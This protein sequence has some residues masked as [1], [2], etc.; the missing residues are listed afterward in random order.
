MDLKLFGP[1]CRGWL[2]PLSIAALLCV[3]FAPHPGYAEG[4]NARQ[5]FSISTSASAGVFF[6]QAV[7]DIY[8]QFLSKDYKN[9]ELVWPFTPLYYS[10]A[11]LSLVTRMGF[12]ADLDVRQGFAGKTGSM[13]DSDF[14]NGDAVRTHFSQSDSYTERALLLDLKAGY[15]FPMRG[16]LGLGFFGGLSYMDFKWSARD[17]YYQYPTS[18]SDYYW[19]SSGVFHAGTHPAWSVNG[20]KTPL[21]G[22]GILYEQAYVIGSLGFKASYRLLGTLSLGAYCAVSPL[23]Y[24]YTE[25]NHEFR[26]VD[27]YSRLAGGFMIEPGLNLEYRIKPGASLELAL[28][29]RQ[30]TNLKGDITQVDQG[31]T[32]T[33]SGGNFYAGPVSSTTSPGG[34]G[35]S[36]WMVDASLL[37]RLVF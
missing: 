5:A 12:F 25:D 30:V 23:A 36:M 29:Y 10:G 19:D 21:Y 28:D 33:S 13:T 7:E 1:Q 2:F 15:D 37:F 14:L 8:N 9:S 16:P 6:G 22:T 32:A 3:L 17:G 20:T 35:A 18:G 11:G 31:T 26:L 4:Q 24:C 27:F 34:S